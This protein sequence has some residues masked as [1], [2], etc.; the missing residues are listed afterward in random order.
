M[1]VHLAELAVAPVALDELLLAGDRLG[2]RLDVLDRPGV[3]LDALAVVGAVVAAERGQATVAQ[4]PDPVDG[5]VEEGPVVRRDQQRAG[6]PPKVLLEPLERVEVEVVGRFVEQ[7]E[8]RVG[9]DQARQRRPGLLAA[10]QRRR[11]LRPL[12]AREPEPAQR[13]LDPLVEGVAAEDLVLVQ[14]LGVGVVRDPA[15]AL[16]RGQPLGHPV[17]MGGAGPDRRPEVRRGHERLV[18]MR[19]LGEQPEGQPALAVDLAAVGLVAPG[20]Q[21]EQRRLARAVRPDQP[22][23]VAERDRRV[24]RV[25]DDERP[26][27]AGHPGQPQDAHRT[28]PG[29]AVK[30]RTPVPRPVASPRPVS[31]ARSV[32]GP[33]P[34]PPHPASAPDSPPLPARSSAVP[35]VAARRSSSA[36]SRRRPSDRPRRAA[37]TTSRN[38]STG[39][40]RRSA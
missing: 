4:L 40:R 5:R 37:G 31:F 18:E 32:P 15:V 39:R 8:V 21:P 28:G 14:E 30:E 12:V 35:P 33:R 11:R 29:G 17:E 7:Q 34:T 9:D 2:L 25:E 38:A 6:P 1:L 16:H 13:R 20:R 24:D 26:D 23:P 10:R 22:D 3:A 27:L 36:G 19:L